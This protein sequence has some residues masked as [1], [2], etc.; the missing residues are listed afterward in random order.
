MD[1]TFARQ[2]M[3]DLE[4][5]LD[6]LDEAL[7]VFNSDHPN[8]LAARFASDDVDNRTDDVLIILARIEKSIGA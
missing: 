3:T 6:A 8:D 1:T 2:M 5:A 7:E 4:K